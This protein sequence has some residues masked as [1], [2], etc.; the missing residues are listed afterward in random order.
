VRLF[1]AVRPSAAAAVALAQD[2][3]REVDDRWH[4]TLAFLGE[5]PGPEPFLDPL[6]EVATR[7]PP[8]SLSLAGG[9]T[10]GGRVLSAGVAGEVPALR[11]LAGE[12]QASCGNAGADL[13]ERPFRPHLTVA[14]GRG[15]RVPTQ[16]AAHQGPAWQVGGFDLVL[17]LLGRQT[18]HEVLRRFPLGPPEAA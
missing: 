17:S 15:L 2:L 5:Q 13:Q 6:A 3:G 1:V 4:V 11:R 9:K 12:V 14:R 7:T 18:R 8:F 16:L 10:F